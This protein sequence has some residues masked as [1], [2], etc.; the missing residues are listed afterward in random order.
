MPQTLDADVALI[1][2]AGG[3]ARVTSPPGT[4]AQTPPRRAARGRGEDMLFVSLGLHAPRLVSPALLD[5]LAHQAARAYYGTP[6]SVTS[7]L[8]EAAA[9]VNDQLVEANRNQEAIGRLQG[10]LVAAVLRG[11]DLYICQCGLGQAILV[12]P[13]QVTRLASEE[14]ANRPLGLTATPFVRYHHLE[15]HPGDLLVLTCAPP[16][17]WSDPTLSGLSGL[18]PAQALDRLVAAS[19]TDLTG[20]LMRV[21]QPGAASV[22]A[23][24]PRAVAHA[25]M[26]EETPPA[27]VRPVARPQALRPTIARPEPTKPPLEVA[28]PVAPARLR[29][30][31]S[32]PAPW[33][34]SLGTAMERLDGWSK[35]L[36]APLGE[37]LRRLAPGLVEPQ[38]ASGIPP[39]VMAAT[40]VA[41]PLVVVTIAALVYFRS[42]RSEL[43]QE[44]LT[45][46]QTSVVAAQLKPSPQEA[47]P[48]WEA[49]LAWL[50]L[51]EQYRQTQESRTLRQQV[52]TALDALNRVSR[53]EYRPAV[54]GGFGA[55]A[56]I[57]AMAAT[58][59]DLYVLDARRLVIW[60][61]WFTGRGFEIDRDFDCLNGPGSVPGMTAPVGLVSLSEPGALLTPGIVAIDEDGTLVYCAPDS[62]LAYSQLTPPDT[63]W[64][65]IQAVDVF[66]DKLYVL[67]PQANSV[68]IYDAAGG[69]FSETPA[70]YFVDQVPDLKEAIDLALAQ[71]QLLLLF[72]D[73]HIESCRRTVEEAPGGG[74]RIRVECDQGMRFQSDRP[75]QEST[76]HIPGAMPIEM[77]YSPPPEPSLY[78]LD[79][80]SD[81][82]Y[83]YS[84]RL[85]Y[86]GQLLPVT[87][88]PTRPTALTLGPPNDLFVAVGDQVYYAQ[89]GR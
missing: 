35:A 11:R 7:A 64:G 39:A 12:R 45:Q 9:E 87:S 78:F 85:V 70:F 4:L 42:G 48:D 88:F 81:S 59:T 71:D 43:F 5:Q 57:T 69:L 68:W 66:G 46:A 86:Q 44:Y 38:A 15:V 26:P 28:E 23:P 73:G 19:A 22:A 14:A 77:A 80:L 58:S 55:N 47:W 56:Q 18:E 2:V 10:R 51:A 6:G 49:A 25:T 34:R 29:R 37:W 62:P 32:A 79:S 72:R 53:L 67:D 65:K 50:D 24:P 52:Q 27:E 74:T 36:S 30:R 13:G 76:E 3:E 21:A 61:S 83:I 31:P 82:V 17:G 20:I 40:A 33:R 89:P 16:P 1:H 75:G 84:M 8:R 60:H 41:V 54:S 63:G